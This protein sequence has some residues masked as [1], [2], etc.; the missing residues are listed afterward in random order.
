[1]QPNATELK[2]L[3]LLA[4][5]DKTKRGQCG[6]TV[7]HPLRVSGV[8]TRPPWPHFQRSVRSKPDQTGPNEPPIWNFTP[9]VLPPVTPA[10]T[11]IQRCETAERTRGGGAGLPVVPAKA[12][13]SHPCP[14]SPSFQRRLE[15]SVRDNGAHTG[16]RGEA[17]KLPARNGSKWKEREANKKFAAPTHS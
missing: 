11:G 2:V 16:R 1:M 17:P 15:S 13:T 14:L 5:P 8:P 9:E 6:L 10:K 4:T 12:G 3:P 7:A